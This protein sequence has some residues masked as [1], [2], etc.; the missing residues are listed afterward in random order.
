M[1]N[2][3]SSQ[4]KDARQAPEVLEKA[5]SVYLKYTHDTTYGQRI[6]LELLKILKETMTSGCCQTCLRVGQDTPPLLEDAFVSSTDTCRL[7]FD[8]LSQ[9]HVFNS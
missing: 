9:K 7:Q 1:E 4:R 5:A 8:Q 2:R 3:A 6:L